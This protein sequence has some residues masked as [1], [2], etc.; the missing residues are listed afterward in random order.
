[1]NEDCPKIKESESKHITNDQEGRLPQGFTENLK[2]LL[3][4]LGIKFCLY[5]KP[6][7]EEL[8]AE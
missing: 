8:K 2:L 3:P 6:N 5:F 1:M 4:T 7:Q